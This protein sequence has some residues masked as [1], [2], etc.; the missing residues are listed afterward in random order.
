MDENVAIK[1]AQKELEKIT[2]NEHVRY[3]VEFCNKNI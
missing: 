3:L 2:S 1:K